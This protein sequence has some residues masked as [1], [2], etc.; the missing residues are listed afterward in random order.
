[1]VTGILTGLWQNTKRVVSGRSVLWHAVAIALTATFVLT[2]FDWWFY[3]M[4]RSELFNPLIWTAGIGGFFVPVLA[5]VGIYN[6]GEFRHDERVMSVAL[7]VGQAVLIA[8]A[9]AIVY[10]ALTGR[11][12]PEFMN[13]I[14]NT[15]I[16]RDFNFGLL[17]HGVFW[18][19]PSSHTIVAFAGGTVLLRLVQHVSARAL[20][21][22]YMI[23]VAVGAGVGFHWL[24]DVVAGGV[25]GILIGTIVARNFK[26]PL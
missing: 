4:T 11:I 16:S 18:G 2:G 7:A 1:M 13:T 17:R 20:T 6:Y 23:V 8:L 25:L 3:E 10:K 5:I 14:G 26:A 9:A 22:L 19:W 24:S 15:D 21:A 12:Q